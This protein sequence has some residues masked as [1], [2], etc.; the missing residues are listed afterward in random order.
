MGVINTNKILD[1]CIYGQI[2]AKTHIKRLIA[3]WIN[4]KMEGNVFGIHGPPG[5]GKTTLC[6]KGFTKCL[7]D[8]NNEKYWS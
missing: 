1:E 8:E 5:V 6:K 3:Q 2:E 7:I 4:G